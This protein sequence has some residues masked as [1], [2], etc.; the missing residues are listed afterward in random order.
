MVFK[1]EVPRLPCRGEDWEE[2]G[3]GQEG[4][5]GVRARGGRGDPRPGGGGGPRPGAGGAGGRRWLP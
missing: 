2:E 1:K 3:R 4:G 5:G